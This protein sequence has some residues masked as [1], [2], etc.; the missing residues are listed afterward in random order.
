MAPLGSL[1]QPLTD[2]EVRQEVA[3]SRLRCLRTFLEL[4]AAA[5]AA[6]D[7]VSS[8]AARTPPSTRAGGQDDGSETNSL[9]L[10]N[11]LPV[12]SFLQP[13]VDINLRAWENP[14][15]F[16]ALLL[17]IHFGSRTQLSCVC[18]TGRPLL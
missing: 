9:K 17:H 7:V 2:F 15:T 8:T 3:S 13:R 14:M 6:A 5:T 1:G 11:C 10:S 12:H 16:C 4:V 18:I